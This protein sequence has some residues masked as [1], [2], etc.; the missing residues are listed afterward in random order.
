MEYK[1]KKLKS[2]KE[3]KLPTQKFVGRDMDAKKEKEKQE[4]KDAS[5]SK[6]K[7][8]KKKLHIF[9]KIFVALIGIGLLGAFFAFGMLKGILDST[10]P[11]SSFHFGPTKFA[12]NILDRNG[13]L[14]NM[15]VQEGS[16]RETAVYYVNEDPSIGRISEIPQKLVDAFVAIEDER[17]WEHSGVDIRSIFRAVYGVIHSDSSRGGG[18]TITQQLVKNAVFNDETKGL[19]T[20][21]E[22]GFEKYV[23]KLQEQYIALQYETQAEMS[24]KEIKEQIITDYL[25]TIN[26]GSNTLGVKVAAKRYFDKDLKDLTVSECAV[27]ASITKNPTRNNPITHPEENKK[28]QRQTLKNMLTLNYITQEE[29]DEAV[30][31]DVYSRIK[32]I[33]VKVIESANVNEIYKYFTESVIDQLQEDLVKRLGYTPSLANNLLYS[34]GLRVETTM[35]PDIQAIVDKEVNDDKNYTVKKYAI[36]Y[37]L[38]I[39]HSDDS[40][41]H[42]SQADVHKYH[43]E[44]LKNKKYDGLFNTKDLAQQYINSFKDSI[45]KEGDTIAGETLNY[46][47]EPQCSFVIINHNTGEVVA[48]AGGRGEK[49]VSRS[50]NRATVTKR[51]PGSTFKVLSA[52]APALELYNKTLATTYYDSEYK[53]TTNTMSKTFKNWY[54]SGYLGFQNIRAGIIYSLNIIAIRC[55]METVTPEIGVQFVKSLGV[56][57]DETQDA[58]PALAL[59]GLT[60]G[61]TNYELTSAFASIANNGVYRK[62]ILYTKVYDH[63]GKILLDNTKNQTK[64]VMSKENAYLLTSAMA[65]SMLGSKAYSSGSM[66][67]NSTSTRAHFKGMSLAG[68][69]GT[70]TKNNDIWFVGYS[71][72]YTA[73]VWGGCDENQSLQDTSK[74]INNGGTNFHKN[75]WRKIMEQVHKNLKD[76]KFEKPAGIISKTVCR[77]SGL[78]ASDGCKLD[79]RGDCTYT[80]YFVDGTQP[81]TRCNIHSKYGTINIPNKYKELVTDDL[82]FMTPNFDTIPILP[83]VPALPS[84]PGSNIIIAPTTP[85]VPQ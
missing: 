19:N 60:Y 57:I 59:G 83:D 64:K 32:N 34:G 81:R 85:I 30:N 10:P 46:F 77:K 26:L 41:T 50:L 61:V 53:Y 12:T 69:S 47:L 25:N 65:D 75:I 76:P 23:R 42:Y 9:R 49:T 3:I 45:A 38:S 63:D 21:N 73:G 40:L 31:D 16:N 44:T 68:K 2:I 37:R 80:E 17:F 11:L 15:L 6:K 56:N 22:K 62:P 72:Y 48:L 4:A 84:E 79:L 58:N 78:L 66:N 20:Y 28:R 18:S 70:T 67:I 35:D 52:F 71:P 13:N 55:L 27:I 29:Y 5:H 74:R 14:L 8:R 82:K 39:R 43:T 54:S 51:Q 1:L 7:K 36:D 33:E 24:K